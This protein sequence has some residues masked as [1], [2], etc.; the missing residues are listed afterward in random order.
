MCGHY[1]HMDCVMTWIKEE[2]KMTC[3]ICRK[4]IRKA[5]LEWFHGER[6]GEAEGGKGKG[7]VGQGGERV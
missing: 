5:L 1:F 7:K 3:P 4:P 2:E 6:E